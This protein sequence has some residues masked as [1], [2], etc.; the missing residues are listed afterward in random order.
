MSMT[1]EPRDYEVSL[2]KAKMK[3]RQTH[4]M[5]TYIKPLGSK[6]SLAQLLKGCVH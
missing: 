1:R 4:A 5:S 3:I 2:G 6:G